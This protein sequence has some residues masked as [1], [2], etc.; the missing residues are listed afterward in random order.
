MYRLFLALRYLLTRPINLLGMAGITISVWA[1]VVVV[2]LFSGFLQVVESHVHEASADVVVGDLPA[3]SEWRK[4]EAAL[5]DDPNVAG[6][7]PRL[8]HYGILARPGH[9][10]PTPPLPGRSALHGGDQPFL[11]V[12]GVDPVAEASVTGFAGWLVDAS[13]PADLRA[14]EPPLAAAA[15]G[16]PAVLVGLDRMRRDGLRRGD[17]VL[18]TTAQLRSDGKG[19]KTPVKVQIDLVVAGAFKTAHGGF[20]GN[21]VFVAERTLRERLFPDQ[22]DAVQEAAVKVRDAATLDATAERLQRAV[23]RATER[24]GHGFGTAETWRQRNGTFLESI[25]HQRGLMQLVLVVI[26]VVAAFLMLAT[27]SMMVTEKVSDIGILTAMGGTPRGVA[28]VFLACGVV[29]TLA[30]VVAGLAIGVVTG[31]YLE[32]VRQAVRWATGIDLFP[33]D[34]YNLDRVPCAIEPLWL[35]QVAAMALGVG[36]VVSFLPAWRAARH[37]PLVSLRGL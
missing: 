21:T 10:P 4:V 11:F 2:S 5:R 18:L 36:V 28:S 30:G 35:M 24:D 26:M 3:W 13:I 33:I 37:D 9:R 16:T 22:P 8:L 31:V 29:I 14:A 25:A 23:L 12:Q 1:L 19:G 32:E 17:R 27:L 6:V 15:D 7:A 34:V 20:D